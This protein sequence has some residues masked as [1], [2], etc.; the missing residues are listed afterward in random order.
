MKPLLALSGIGTHF[1]VAVVDNKTE[2]FSMAQA[3]TIKWL[4]CRVF[5]SN[6]HNSPTTL[7][8]LIFAIFIDWMDF[9]EKIVDS[10]PAK[11][12]SSH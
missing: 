9:S 5:N 11:L 1:R 8:A 10:F 7:I 4:F 2:I 3:L 6:D 12:S